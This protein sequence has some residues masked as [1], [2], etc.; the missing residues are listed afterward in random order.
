MPSHA[1]TLPMIPNG[2]GI[3][4]FLQTHCPG[5]QV[6]SL[7]KLCRKR[8]LFHDP[9]GRRCVFLSLQV[10]ASRLIKCLSHGPAWTQTTRKQCPAL[11]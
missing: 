3:D 6:R 8:V 11:G 1:S 7:W 2:R 9:C 10:D 4:L 5:K